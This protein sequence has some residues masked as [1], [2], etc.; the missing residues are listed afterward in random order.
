MTVGVQNTMPVANGDLAAQLHRLTEIVIDGQARTDARLDRIEN[1]ISGLRTD[2]T[3][4]KSDV[5]GLKTDVAVLKTDVAVLKT[6]VAVLK[7]DM[8]E[9]KAQLGRLESS[10]QRRFD[11][12]DAEF[13]SWGVYI[14][15]EELKKNRLQPPR[16]DARPST[17]QPAGGASGRDSRRS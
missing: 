6:D 13:E 10:T 2:V 7:T 9:S 8:A 1:D 4:L 12:V 15:N 17:K 14:K 16:T 3:G 11:R 5:A